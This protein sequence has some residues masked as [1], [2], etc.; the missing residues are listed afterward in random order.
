M[1]CP[2]S[3]LSPFGG[4]EKWANHVRRHRRYHCLV[5]IPKFMAIASVPHWKNS[6][7][8]LKTERMPLHCILAVRSVGRSIVVL[9]PE[10]RCLPRSRRGSFSAAALS[11]PF[12][13]SMASRLLSRGVRP[14]ASVRPCA[15]RWQPRL[16]E[17][18]SEHDNS[19]MWLEGGG[20]AAAAAAVRLVAH[21]IRR[22]ARARQHM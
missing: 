13:S 2:H 15:R 21:I 4:V 6:A 22:P 9:G 5:N 18:C 10:G 20:A 12:R 16:G 7:Y 1:V 11:P 3:L 17:A 19:F 8:A 14:S